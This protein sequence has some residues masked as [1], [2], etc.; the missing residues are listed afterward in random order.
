MKPIFN[1]MI[2]LSCTFL[3]SQ[4][5]PPNLLFE[6]IDSKWYYFSKDTNNSVSPYWFRLPIEIKHKDSFLFIFEMNTT[7]SPY[8]G[9]DGSI[10]SKLNYHTGK[11]NWINLFNHYS[12]NDQRYDFSKGKLTIHENKIEILG[13]RDL[14]YIDTTAP[15]FGFY[16][17]P[18]KAVL[19]N[20]M[21]QIIE[22]KYGDNTIKYDNHYVGIGDKFMVQNHYGELLYVK[23]HFDLLDS[24]YN[25]I[26]TFYKI[27]EDYNI[28]NDSIY[29]LKYKTETDLNTPFF[30]TSHNSIILNNNNNLG[31]VII[32]NNAENI[33]NSPT[34]AYINVVDISELDKIKDVKTFSFL[35]EIYFPQ[36]LWN[37]IIVNSIN[38]D[39]VIHQTMRPLESPVS[40]SSFIWLA[41]YDYL[42]N[43]KSKVDF[44]KI[45]DL[46]Y[47]DIRII[48]VI[49]DKLYITGYYEDANNNSKTDILYL[50][51][52]ESE[53]KKSF[54][55]TL[56]NRPDILMF[57]NRT[58]ILPNNDLILGYNVETNQGEY[59]YY[60][61]F[62][63][64]T[65]GLSTNSNDF[66][67]LSFFSISPNPSSS[68]IE[69]KT[70]ADYDEVIIYNLEGKI[71]KCI[72]SNDP[73]IDIS[74]LADATYICEI[75]KNG[76]VVGSGGRFVK[77]E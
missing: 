17:V 57:V 33:F 24:F 27:N 51:E 19:S 68:I 70:D 60:Y 72:K 7:P 14:E 41:W 58:H 15:N 34:K 8:K 64:K 4:V 67:N 45:A 9:N 11:L 40:S 6:E 53:F 49:D 59:Q 31:I 1:L 28:S 47:R 26:V 43:K 18:F 30:P 22:K 73:Q 23:H 12:G 13:F 54:T 16:G 39:I 76:K 35:D 66:R 69:I 5:D 71:V 55:L 56:K 25:Y 77:V 52:G 2:F 10:V 48:G 38:T 63:A 42:G 61:C 21:G 32:E 36:D 3:Y 65:L 37:P 50:I 75:K 29:Y 46:Y 20:E 62:D 74:S 44:V